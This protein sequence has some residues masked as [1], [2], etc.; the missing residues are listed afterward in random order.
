M[1]PD[2]RAARPPPGVL[3]RP[4]GELRLQQYQQLPPGDDLQTLV[5][6]YLNSPLIDIRWT[7]E[8]LSLLLS[9]YFHNLHVTRAIKFSD[10]C[11]VDFISR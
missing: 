2:D 9:H 8:R 11:I 6:K 5:L 7:G 3:L 1:P 4:L 10:F